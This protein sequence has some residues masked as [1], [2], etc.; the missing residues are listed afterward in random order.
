[1]AVKPRNVTEVGSAGLQATVNPPA[2]SRFATF[3]MESMGIS[4]T[5]SL[6]NDTDFVLLSATV[7]ANPTV[8]L[9]KSLEM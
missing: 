4:D 2:P 3:T 5:R 1:M 6:H 9:W 7:G 8:F